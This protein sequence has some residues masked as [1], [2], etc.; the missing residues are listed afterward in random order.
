MIL[1]RHAYLLLEPRSPRIS[2]GQLGK[3]RDS[4]TNARRK[5]APLLKRVIS[6]MKASFLKRVSFDFDLRACI[7]PRP[8]VSEVA[9]AVLAVSRN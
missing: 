7:G 5:I 2:G 1:I 9:V 4:T 6:R 3:K 8:Q